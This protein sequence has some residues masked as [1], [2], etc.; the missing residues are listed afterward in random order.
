MKFFVRRLL[1]GIVIVPLAGVAYA[2]SCLML[3]AYGANPNGNSLADYFG[4]GMVL[5][6]FLTLAF[7]FDALRRN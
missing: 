6:V 3:I 2:F 1:A 5:G 4:F 7:A